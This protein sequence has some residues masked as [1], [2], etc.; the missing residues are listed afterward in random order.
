MSAIQFSTI[1]EVRDYVRNP[2]E[3]TCRT[4]LFGGRKIYKKD[5]NAK[6]ALPLNRL[7]RNLEHF[8]PTNR[9]EKVWVNEVVDAIRSIDRTTEEH[10]QKEVL[11]HSPFKRLL[12]RIKRFF[13]NSARKRELALTHLHQE[14]PAIPTPTPRPL[15]R[16]K[17]EHV[18]ISTPPRSPSTKMSL[19][20]TPSK[21]LNALEQYKEN[22]ESLSKIQKTIL[23][24]NITSIT[25]T[26]AIDA[27]SSVEGFLRQVSDNLE[28]IIELE[29]PNCLRALH[30]IYMEVTEECR[31]QCNDWIVGQPSFSPVV[32]TTLLNTYPK[33]SSQGEHF[34]V[35]SLKF[36]LEEYRRKLFAGW[37]LT[38]E[39]KKS[40]DLAFNTAIFLDHALM[41]S[42]LEWMIEHDLIT[43]ESFQIMIRAYIRKAKNLPKG[44]VVNNW[45]G[46]NML[47]DLYKRNWLGQDLVKD[48]ETYLRQKGVIAN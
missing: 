7:I 43:K 24:T 26:L 30:D 46:E 6:E 48:V 13:T 28:E 11:R 44:V 16:S 39:Q 12:T 17:K 36:L 21:R 19:Q 8:A 41:D 5:G 45:T 14:V 10:L 4:T 25:P 35:A 1:Q 9:Q 47:I 33:R 20:R 2:E 40:V 29:H 34:P 38:P 18:P 3:F 37:E 27:L 15:I 23:F 22:P 32:L 31:I 42:L